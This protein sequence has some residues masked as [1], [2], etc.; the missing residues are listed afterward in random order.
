[1][2]ELEILKWIVFG[3]MG[4]A[5]WFMKNTLTETK[6]RINDLEKSMAQIPVNFLHRDDFKE[7][8]LELRGMFEEIRKDIRSINHPKDEA[9]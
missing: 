8:K 3:I 6:E 5:V 1:M 4:V 7:F 2:T 9:H